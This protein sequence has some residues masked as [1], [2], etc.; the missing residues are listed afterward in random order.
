MNQA[1]PLDELPGQ[2]VAL[3]ARLVG[4]TLDELTTGYTLDDG[5][6]VTRVFLRDSVGQS[7]YFAEFDAGRTVFLGW[8]KPTVGTLLEAL[9]RRDDG[10]GSGADR[11]DWVRARSGPTRR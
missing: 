4:N 9:A 3:V 11:L 5:R 8:R 10:Y 7:G 2:A 6:T 1:A